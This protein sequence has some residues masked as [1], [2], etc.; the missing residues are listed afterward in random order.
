MRFVPVSFESY[1]MSHSLVEPSAALWHS[2]SYK[3]DALCQLKQQKKHLLFLTQWLLLQDGCGWICKKFRLW[4]LHPGIILFLSASS[5]YYSQELCFSFYF[6]IYLKK[7]PI[8]WS[9]HHERKSV[10]LAHSDVYYVKIEDKKT[11]SP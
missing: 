4:I 11:A 3:C 8:W 9:R 10:L 7:S 5:F 1:T 6:Q 2:L